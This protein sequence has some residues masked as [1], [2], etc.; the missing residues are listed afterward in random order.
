MYIATS[1]HAPLRPFLGLKESTWNKVYPSILSLA[2][3][4]FLSQVSESP[5]AIV[6]QHLQY[7]LHMALYWGEF[8]G[9]VPI[10]LEM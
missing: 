7:H 5:I 1:L 3:L 6:Y 8:E 9:T 10:Y 4:W 2:S